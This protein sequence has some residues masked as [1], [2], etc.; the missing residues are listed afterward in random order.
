MWASI[1]GQ[2]QIW[3]VAPSVGPDNGPRVSV[4]SD[5][6]YLSLTPAE[7]ATLAANLLAAVEAG[8]ATAEVSK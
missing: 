6:L 1:T 5:S 3:K 7:A 8:E 4:F 2:G